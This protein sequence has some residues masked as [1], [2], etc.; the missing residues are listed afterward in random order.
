MPGPIDRF[1]RDASA[2]LRSFAD[3][4]PGLTGPVVVVTAVAIFGTAASIVLL[5]RARPRLRGPLAAVAAVL[6]ADVG[7]HVVGLLWN[8]PRPFVAMHV[9]PLFP[10]AA[11]SSFPSS[12][13]AFVA[14]VATVAWFAWRRLGQVLAVATFVTA[15]GCVYVS[16]HYIS[17]VVVGALIGALAAVVAWAAS[18]GIC[19]LAGARSQLAGQALG[20]QRLPDEE[21]GRG[22]QFG[23]HR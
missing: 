5:F 19:R 23:E 10:H 21:V 11:N 7:S 6:L 1:D 4:H 15:F 22:D 18:A 12:T 17:D 14:A 13:V 3:A 20:D 9:S 2:T 8:R 16:V